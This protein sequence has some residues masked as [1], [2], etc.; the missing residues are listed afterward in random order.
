MKGSKTM[1]KI[2]I[3]YNGNYVCS[4]TQR[5]TCK[6]AKEKFA[7]NPVWQGLKNDNTIGQCKIEN[8]QFDKIKCYFSK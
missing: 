5:K 3:Y 1:K 8:I 2:D 6:E 7:A 4:T